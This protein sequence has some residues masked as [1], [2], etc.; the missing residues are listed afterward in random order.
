MAKEMV[1]DHTA[2]NKDMANVRRRNGCA[3]SPKK[4]NKDGQKEYDKLNGL[5]GKDFDTRICDLHGEGALR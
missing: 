3:C 5:S 4:M 1:D 2:M